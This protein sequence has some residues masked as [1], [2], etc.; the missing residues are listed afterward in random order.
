[1]PKDVARWAQGRAVVG[2]R[3]LWTVR[4]ALDVPPDRRPNGWLLKF[5][6][7]TRPFGLPRI[8]GRRLDG[9]GTF[10]ASVNRADDQSGTWV[11]STLEFSDAGCWEVAARFFDTKAMRFRIR[12]GS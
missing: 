4:S 7:Y 6:W 3:H 12:V 8:D 1:M 9:A 2:R 5:P 10:H 11:A